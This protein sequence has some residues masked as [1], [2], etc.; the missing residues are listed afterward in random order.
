NFFCT[1][2]NS[3]QNDS[4][5][6][7]IVAEDQFL[8]NYDQIAFQPL[9]SLFSYRFIALIL[10][11]FDWKFWTCFQAMKQMAQF[12]FGAFKVM[13]NRWWLLKKTACSRND[14]SCLLDSI[15]WKHILCPEIKW[16]VIGWKDA[17]WDTCT[18]I[19][20]ILIC[21]F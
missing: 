11:C 1:K 20:G 5:P 16:K 4:L 14:L 13:H 10:A 6:K 3:L 19:L 9:K 7:F 18:F 21:I 2:F 8:E 12:Q 15:I 17:L